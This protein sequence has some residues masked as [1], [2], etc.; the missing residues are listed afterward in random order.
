[1]TNFFSNDFR[2]TG[3]DASLSASFQG[4]LS[5]K[6]EAAL[7]TVLH[8]NA[9]WIGF[10]VYST[11]GVMAGSDVKTQVG[12]GNYTLS[13]L[14]G[15]DQR[16]TAESDS[17]LNAAIPDPTPILTVTVGTTV[18]TIDLTA[19][20]SATDRETWT[21]TLGSGKKATSTYHT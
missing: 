20:L 9:D 14:F 13:G 15:A 10:L 1:M 19:I 6:Y 21:E 18:Y 4:Q 3:F 16:K 11:N 5:S 7:R 8:D 17:V 2:G 12:N